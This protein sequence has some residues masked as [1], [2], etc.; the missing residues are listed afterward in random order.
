V[1][2]RTSSSWRRTGK[3]E[4]AI[5]GCA[6]AKDEEVDPQAEEGIEESQQQGRAE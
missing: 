4:I 5:G 6:A 2:R 3:F 1:R